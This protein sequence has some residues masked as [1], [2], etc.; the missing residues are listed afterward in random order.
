MR[1]PVS[2]SIPIFSAFGIPVKVHITYF[3]F[4]LGLFVRQLSL[5]GGAEKALAIFLLTI[6]A[7]FVVVLLHEFGHCFAARLM[8]GDAKEIVIWPLGG[9]A[10]VEFPYEWRPHTIVAAGGLIVQAI[11]GF[12][13]F[14]IL[15]GA[16]YFP[17]FN[18]IAN[19]Y[20]SEMY[21]Y[22]D[23]RHY[24][25]E[26]GLNIYTPGSNELA[27]PTEDMKAKLKS[28]E[29][30]N[31]IIV[32]SGYERAVA[33]A[34]LVWLNRI[35]W[36]NWVLILI[37]LIPGLPLDGGQILYGLVWSRSDRE[38]A[39]QTTVFTGY[40]VAVLLVVASLA[41]NEVFALTLG[42]IIAA[43]CWLKVNG[44]QRE[45]QEFGDFSAGYSSLDG[46]DP[47]PRPK[48]R[49]GLLKRWI[50]ARR[51]RRMQRESEQQ[52]KDEQRL[53]QLLE[54]IARKEALTAEEQAFMK[55][56]SARYKNR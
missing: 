42:V 10:N 35:F 5:P 16:G 3:V 24:T 55:R 39:T 27:K 2:W 26:Y 37:N 13:C 23:A 47:P 4:T 1:D 34:G 43:Y 15:A 19:P 51:A 50:T 56:V 48:K 31:E 29:E 30:V 12:A 32:K 33:P 44:P 54:K 28:T 41:L 8:D 52:I 20:T 18:P 17:T 7:L 6:V 46:D 45:E 14:I 11:I 22:R 38:Q 40:F 25:S 9:L 21:N 53:D 49:Q 36:L